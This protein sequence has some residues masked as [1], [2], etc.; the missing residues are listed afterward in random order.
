MSE[1]QVDCWIGYGNR[2]D[3]FDWNRIDFIIFDSIWD[4]IWFHLIWFDLIW[5]DLI[6][7]PCIFFK[8]SYQDVTINK[9]SYYNIRLFVKHLDQEMTVC[10]KPS[11]ALM[12]S[13]SWEFSS[14]CPSSSAT[15]S[16]TTAST[17][18]PNF[19]RNLFDMIPNQKLLLTDRIQKLFL[20]RLR[21]WL[22]QCCWVSTGMSF[23]THLGHTWKTVFFSESPPPAKDAHISPKLLMVGRWPKPSGQPHRRLLRGRPE[24]RSLRPDHGRGWRFPVRTFGVPGGL[25]H[26]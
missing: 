18:P 5:Y 26:G 14:I 22:K 21:K 20:N 24:I 15:A 11:R 2:M 9:W 1:S 12:A 10:R 25:G 13:K 3:W 17:T 7:R 8:T 16:K 4:L 6:W 23:W 19:C